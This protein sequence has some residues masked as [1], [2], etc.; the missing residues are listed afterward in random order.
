MI[1]RA[2]GRGRRSEVGGQRTEVS[3]EKKDVGGPAVAKAMADAAEVGE[4]KT[5]DGE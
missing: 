4:Q 5:E 1:W 3:W 2:G